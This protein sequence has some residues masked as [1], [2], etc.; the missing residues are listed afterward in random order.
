MNQSYILTEPRQKK[1][2]KSFKDQADTIFGLCYI[3]LVLLFS[4]PTWM[5]VFSSPDARLGVAFMKLSALFAILARPFTLMIAM[6]SAPGQLLGVALPGSDTLLQGKF[7]AITDFNALFNGYIV[8]PDPVFLIPFLF[9]VVALVFLGYKTPPDRNVLVEGIKFALKHYLMPLGA[10]VLIWGIA[11]IAFGLWDFG[12]VLTNLFI[13]WGTYWVDF[14]LWI[15]ISIFLVAVGNFMAGKKLA[16]SKEAAAYL[17]NSLQQPTPRSFPVEQTVYIKQP[18]TQI[19]ADQPAIE[20]AYV[21][22]PITRKY[23]EFCGAKI[24]NG[25]RFCT[26]CGVNLELAPEAPAIVAQSIAIQDQSIQEPRLEPSIQAEIPI[27]RHD[28]VHPHPHHEHHEHHAHHEQPRPLILTEKQIESIERSIHVLDDVAWKIAILIMGLGV[29]AGALAT[30]MNHYGTLAYALLSLPLGIFMIIKDREVFSK[31]IFERNYS[32]RGIEMILFGIMGSACMGAGVL[33]IVKGIL[34]FVFTQGQPKKYPLL[35][36]QQWRALLFQSSLTLSSTWILLATVQS[37]YRF[38]EFNPLSV[39]FAS[40]TAFIG[41]SVFFVY[42]RF[43][44]PEILRGRIEDMDVA[45]I[46]AGACALLVGGAG[47]LILIQGILIRLQKE[48]K[49]KPADLVDNK[50][51]EANTI[52]SKTPVKNVAYIDIPASNEVP[53]VEGE[54][55]PD[56]ADTPAE[57]RDDNSPEE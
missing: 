51:S 32:S 42:D 44:R 19:S 18:A 13:T 11:G 38:M 3:L 15:G 31:W 45:L 43:L 9:L 20:P 12:Y 1:K 37:I 49:K 28:H 21:P 41:F 57:P 26:S 50:T 29:L 55:H 47:I 35:T 16:G 33:I 7:S 46:V 36:N 54:Q 53:N 34:N 23:C 17:V 40:I 5:D 6:G 24:E 2:S 48:E 27:A 56:H 25:A 22:L 39:V 30:I 10:F 8:V 4:I 52:S 14:L